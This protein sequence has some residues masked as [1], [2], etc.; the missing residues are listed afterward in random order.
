MT[1]PCRESNPNSS[2]V[3]PVAKSLYRGFLGLYVHFI[4]H[5][6]FCTLEILI[7]YTIITMLLVVLGGG[8]VGSLAPAALSPQEDSWYSFPLEAE[9]TQGSQ[10]GW[11]D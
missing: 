5:K 1:C 4:N 3:Q 10:C 7:Y 8:A 2:V 11:K 9:S 6:T